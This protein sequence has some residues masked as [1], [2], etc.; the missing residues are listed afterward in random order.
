MRYQ[1]VLLDF[2][3]TLL[4]SDTSEIEAYTLTLRNQGV[5]DP[6]A[7]FAMYKRINLGLWAAVERGELLP[8]DV[9]AKRFEL[10]MAELGLPADIEQMADDF[11]V[12][13]AT[14]GDLYPG[15]VDVLEELAARARLCLITNGL[16]EVQRPRIE[17]LGIEKYFDAIVVSAEVGVTKPGAAIFAIAF[18]RLGNPAK[19]EVLMVGD[20]LSS[21]IKGGADYGIDTCWYNP[22]GKVAGPEDRITYEIKALRDLLN[23]I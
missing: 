2:D 18:E 12:G 6:M 10:L 16:S 14:H 7:H 13:F 22:N 4:D 11:V 3:H 19:A 1:T 9:R 17:R 21:D 8:T 5:E 15:V 23:L 20:S